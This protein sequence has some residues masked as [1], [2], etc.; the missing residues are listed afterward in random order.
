LRRS[1]LGF[2]MVD[3]HAQ[4]ISRKTQCDKIASLILTGVKH[5]HQIRQPHYRPQPPHL[6]HRGHRRE[7]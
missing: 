7:S 6:L 1:G 5:G 4:I 2:E 3:G